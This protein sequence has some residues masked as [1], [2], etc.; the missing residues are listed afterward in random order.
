M[1]Q[2]GDK[3]VHPLYGAGTI[4]GIEKR[5]DRDTT[6]NYYVVPDTLEADRLLVPVENASNLR[7][8]VSSEDAEEI[9][10]IIRSEGHSLGEQRTERVAHCRKTDW[11]D[12]YAVAALWRDLAHEAKEK[13]LCAETEKMRKR[14]RRLLLSEICLAT[15]MSTEE[16]GM[17]MDNLREKH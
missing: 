1:F 4:R 5:K 9:I 10:E 11:G 2:I 17:L 13:K 8:A 12:P 3:I 16:C 14:A 7:L 6:T 15:G